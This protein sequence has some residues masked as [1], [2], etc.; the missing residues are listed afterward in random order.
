MPVKNIRG[1]RMDHKTGRNDMICCLQETYTLNILLQKENKRMEKIN[2]HEDINS[3]EER[4]I[5][6]Y[7]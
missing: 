3:K 1:G 2:H 5:L 4:E 7:L 6:Y